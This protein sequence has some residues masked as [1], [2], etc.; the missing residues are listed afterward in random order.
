MPA[1]HVK[2]SVTPGHLIMHLLLHLLPLARI[3][4]EPYYVAI[5]QCESP[6]QSLTGEQCFKITPLS[7]STPTLPCHS[8]VHMLRWLPQIPCPYH[9][10]PPHKTHGD[11]EEHALTHSLPLTHLPNHRFTMARLMMTTSDEAHVLLSTAITKVGVPATS[12]GQKPN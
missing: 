3:S 7:T 6:M 11:P 9:R 10:T 2:V 1:C 4:T 12:P 8:H 5:F